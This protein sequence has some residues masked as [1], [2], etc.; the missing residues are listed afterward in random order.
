MI[1]QG[2]TAIRHRLRRSRSEEARQTGRDLSLARRLYAT[3]DRDLKL[4]E[5]QG[6]HFYVQNGV[7]TLYGTVRTELDRDLLVSLVREIPGVKGVV[8]HL[9]LVDTRF[10][11][12][13]ST[14]TELS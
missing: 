13:V 10:Q 14:E 2:L 8:A 6:I 11:E 1:P 4:A 7:V 3:F 12:S 9:Q 5:I